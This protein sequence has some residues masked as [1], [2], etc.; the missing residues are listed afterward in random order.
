MTWY[1]NMP[2]TKSVNLDGLLHRSLLLLAD[3]LRRGRLVELLLAKLAHD[4]GLMD[5]L[6]LLQVFHRTERLLT[7]RTLKKVGD[8]ER[9]R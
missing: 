7:L 4:R 2:R 9:R 6:V 1:L 8:V 5:S 3:V